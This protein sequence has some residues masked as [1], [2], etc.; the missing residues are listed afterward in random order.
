MTAN[1]TTTEIQSAIDNKT[2]P[3][4]SLGQLEEIALQ[5]ALIQNTQSPTV[6]KPTIIVFAADHGMTKNPG[7][8]AFPREV[9]AQM[10]LNFVG[11]GAAINVFSKYNDINLIVVDAGVDFEFDPTINIVHNKIW[12]GTK[13]ALVENAMTKD[14]M[15]NSFAK[16]ATLVKQQKEAGCN[17]IGFGE[18]GIGNTAS[19][20]LIY[21]AIL[22]KPVAE[23]TGPGTGVTDIEGKARLL[24]KAQS[25]FT[26]ALTV[27]EA[28]IAFGGFEIA[29]MTGAML[30]AGKQ[31]MTVLVDGFIATAAWL[32]AINI[33]PALSANGILCHQ[34]AEPAHQLILKELN[35][36]PL[37]DLGLRL[38]EGTGAAIAVPIIKVACGFLS[39]MSTFGEASV[40][41][42]V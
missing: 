35:K 42:S 18:M 28:L 36:T 34:S 12:Y 16:G 20:S 14:E 26:H 38:G 30:E 4:G 39:E 8:S 27:E 24:E 23:F 1:V 17:T 3:L 13:D 2:K 37:L 32:I 40:S 25:R 21:S 10:V 6:S 33:E 11:G 5:M 19:A 9:T 41:E 31:N 15:H 7:I 22:N 29:Q